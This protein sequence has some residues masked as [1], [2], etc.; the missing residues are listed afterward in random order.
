MKLKP[1]DKNMT[2]LTFGKKVVLFSYET[3]VAGFTP[4][5]GYVVTNEKY[6]KT[7]TVHINKWL[8]GVKP[9]VVPQSAID[10]L[11]V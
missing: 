10:S 1:L 5:L 4:D 7:T 9:S 8:E 6:S 2:E 3:P 11:L